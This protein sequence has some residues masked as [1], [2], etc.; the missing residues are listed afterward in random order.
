MLVARVDRKSPHCYRV[1]ARDSLRSLPASC[2]SVPLKEKEQSELPLSPKS[3]GPGLLWLSIAAEIRLVSS[4]S[5]NLVCNCGPRLV[6]LP[7]LAQVKAC[8]PIERQFSGSADLN[9]TTA[10]LS[11]GSED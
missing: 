10:K 11:V 3:P 4:R 7:I 9:G 2:P 1:R 5:S 8:C 6:R